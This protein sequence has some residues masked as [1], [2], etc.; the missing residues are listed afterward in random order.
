LD[1]HQ[2]NEQPPLD[3]K[4]FNARKTTT[5]VVGNPGPNLGQVQN[6]AVLNRLM[7]PKS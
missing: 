4:S 2:Q 1:Q 3:L 7:G 5:Y 6:V